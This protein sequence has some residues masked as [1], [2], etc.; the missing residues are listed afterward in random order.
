[1]IRPST[2]PPV[3]SPNTGLFHTKP[4]VLSACGFVNGDWSCQ[5]ASQGATPGPGAEV[6]NASENECKLKLAGYELTA[7]SNKKTPPITIVWRCF[8]SGG[9]IRTT[10]LRVMSRSRGLL[11]FALLASLSA[12]PDDLWHL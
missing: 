1:M 9:W 6:T 4:V 3:S 11:S 12:I 8:Y 10:G 5:L 2:H 7:E